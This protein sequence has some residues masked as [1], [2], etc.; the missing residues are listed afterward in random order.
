[1]RYAIRFNGIPLS[2][3]LA[4]DPALDDRQ[5]EAPGTDADN[6]Y[7]YSCTETPLG[8]KS[9]L[10]KLQLRRV[11]GSP[12]KVTAFKAEAAVPSL[13]LT[14]SSYPCYTKP[15]ASAT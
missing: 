6:R 4:A 5:L 11:D 1:M 7:E 14:A 3:T 13:D 12:F 9:L 8:P 15:S 2:V 10:L